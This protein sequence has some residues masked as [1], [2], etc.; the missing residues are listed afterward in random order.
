MSKRSLLKKSLFAFS[1]IS[2]L[3]A[4]A[5]GSEKALL[6]NLV[7]QGYLTK[8]QAEEIEKSPETP[9][10]VIAKGKD[11]EKMKIS[12]RLQL[13]YNNFGL[14]G[15]LNDGRSDPQG[16]YFRRVY[17]GFDVQLNESWSGTLITNL[18]GADPNIYLDT[19][20]INWHIDKNTM[21][22]VGWDK[23]P[24]G[25]EET[26]S[27][28]RLKTIER[29]MVAR[30]FDFPLR[31]S[32]QHTGVFLKGKIFDT[33]LSYSLFA[34]NN[35]NSGFRSDKQF[36]NINA[37]YDGYSG[38][39]RVQYTAEGNAGKLVV[40]VDAGYIES[41][42]YNM[43]IVADENSHAWVYGGH[44]AYTLQGFNLVTE[45]LGATLDNAR[46]GNDDANIYGFSV[47]PAFK[48]TDE[49]E[50]VAQYSYMDSDGA[51]VVFP[52]EVIRRSNASVVGCDTGQQFYIG[53]NWYIMGDDLKLQAGYEAGRF[54]DPVD[55][56][57]DKARVD[58]V[59]VQMQM[60][61]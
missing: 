34:G 46:G 8:A 59:R 53:A 49:F 4:V 44:A 39:G 32:A 37:K 43:G 52:G 36:N 22:S 45:I 25:Y 20:L 23:V 51:Y 12:G 30:V 21:L 19:G 18:A 2:S 40:G 58:G 42:A 11:V 26:I 5:Y 35:D 61:W 41:G 10:V 54:K 31:T 50:L 28:A 27:S 3:I 1:S 9:P 7:T 56:S 15:D 47:T 17:I 57:G 33:G 14:S 13:Q 16:F 29:S 38:F 48:I 60:Q 24:F 55:G 6:D